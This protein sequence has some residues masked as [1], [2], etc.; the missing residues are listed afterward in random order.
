MFLANDV[1]HDAFIPALSDLMQD[2]NH[3]IKIVYWM[4]RNKISQWRKWHS[5][6]LWVQTL[7]HIPH[8]AISDYLLPT[9]KG[10]LGFITKCSF[11][12][13]TMNQNV[14]NHLIIWL[15]NSYWHW[16]CHWFV[17]YVQLMQVKVYCCLTSIRVAH[18]TPLDFWVSV[19]SN[20]SRILNL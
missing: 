20:F 3:Y 13:L 16:K 12:W 18:F 5:F 14:K 9:H 17:L 2:D 1:P 4:D 19:L 8:Q 10:C 15:S 7:V 6:C 11:C